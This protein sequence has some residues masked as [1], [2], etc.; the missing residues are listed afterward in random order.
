MVIVGTLLHPM[1][2]VIMGCRRSFGTMLFAYVLSAFARSML[3]GKLL[4][5]VYG[6]R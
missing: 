1:F 6:A 2:F 4:S 3:S 5:R